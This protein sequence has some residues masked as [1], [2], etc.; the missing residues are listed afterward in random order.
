MKLSIGIAA[1]ALA[2]ASFSAIDASAVY[3]DPA[4]TGQA[5]IYPYYTA[6]SSGGS[7][8]NTLVT[9]VNR[10]TD[11]KVIRVRFREGRNAREVAS[12]NLYL[13]ASD[14]WTAAVIADAGG[15]RLITAD[16][17]CVNPVFPPRARK[18][19]MAPGW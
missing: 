19:P 14:T 12:F 11:T 16:Q 4:G 15:A 6:Q 8:L 9:V 1:A 10:G 17:S 2:A 3:L 5:L 7:P 13:G 18:S